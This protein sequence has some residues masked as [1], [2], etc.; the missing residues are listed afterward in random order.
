[1]NDEKL[2]IFNTICGTSFNKE[3]N[4]AEACESICFVFCEDVVL[5]NTCKYWFQRLNQ[6]ILMT[7]ALEHRENWRLM[8]KII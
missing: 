6:I 5:H 3:K 8:I 1:M 7:D 2:Y 4:I